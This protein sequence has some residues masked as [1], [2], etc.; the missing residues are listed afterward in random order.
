MSPLR[1]PVVNLGDTFKADAQALRSKY[2]DLD[3]V[4]DELRETL[5][6]AWNVPHRAIEGQN[7]DVYGVALDYPPLA[8]AGIGA[9]FVTYHASAEAENKMAQPLRTYTLLSITERK[10]PPPR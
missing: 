7:P 5:T 10:Q 9:L 2:H 8:S 6:V 4:I 1:A 3:A